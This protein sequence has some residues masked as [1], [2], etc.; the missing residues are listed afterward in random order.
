MKLDFK[1]PCLDTE[2]EIIKENNQSVLMSDLLRKAL[3][4]SQSNDETD[5]IK[6]FD[7][8]LDLKKGV[9]DLDKADQKKLKDFITNEKNFFL[10]TKAQ[11]FKVLEKPKA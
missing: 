10:M 3:M 5:I 11:M 6:F 2:G 7:W 4:T 8:S 1:K 9:L